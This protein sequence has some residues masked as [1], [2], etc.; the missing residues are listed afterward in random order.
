MAEV[1]G[2]IRAPRISARVDY[3]VNRLL[4]A[5]T[6]LHHLARYEHAPS[7]FSLLCSDSLQ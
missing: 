3:A 5:R 1:K 4:F 7:R 6:L 2:S